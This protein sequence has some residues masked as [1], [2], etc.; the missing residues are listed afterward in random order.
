MSGKLLFLGTGGSTGVPVI[1]CTCKVCR[2]TSFRNKRSRSSV[3]IQTQGKNFLIDAGPDFREQALKH[4]IRKLDGLLLTHTHFDHVAGIDD[5]RAFYF[6]NKT[7]LPC[8][9]SKET[10]EEIKIRYHYLMRPLK[11]GHSISAQLDFFVLEHDFGKMR[12]QGVEWKYMSYTQADMKVTGFRQGKMAYVSD[13]RAYTNQLLESLEGVETLVLSALRT[14]PT[15]MHFSVDEAIEFSKMVGAKKTYLTHI[16]HD[17]DHEKVNKIL[18]SN[19]RLSY[20][21]LKISYA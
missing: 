16:S 3:L 20:D 11:D 19:V 21:G 5:L 9:L 8:L 18:P 1:G 10:F 13:I 4:K 12:F 15:Q 2:S 17:L 7:R 6:L 14:T